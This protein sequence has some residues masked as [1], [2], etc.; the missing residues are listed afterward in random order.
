M[1]ANHLV[2][3]ESLSKITDAISLHLTRQMAYGRPTA[4]SELML[5]LVA[6]I[7]VIT[8]QMKNTLLAYEQKFERVFKKMHSHDRQLRECMALFDGKWSDIFDPNVS[9]NIN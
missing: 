1:Q 2:N 8:Q 3:P 9:V 5:G 7:D 6:D 4:E